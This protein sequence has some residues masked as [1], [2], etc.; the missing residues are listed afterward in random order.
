MQRGREAYFRKRY[1]ESLDLF[2]QVLLSNPS[3][4]E[5]RRMLK[6][7]AQAA[8]D[9]EIALVQKERREILDDMKETGKGAQGLD[10][11]ARQGERHEIASAWGSSFF[12]QNGK[13][14]PGT[15]VGVSQEGRSLDQEVGRPGFQN[16]RKAQAKAVESAPESAEKKFSELYFSG[17]DFY[18]RGELLDARAA[19]ER[20]L[21][22][23]P[24]DAKARKALFRVRNELENAPL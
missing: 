1:A 20:A 15:A 5:A 10:K 23:K 16:P 12:D 21:T 19:W 9:Q 4:P 3:H 2:M 18:S 11:I 6:E 13:A 14:R 17:L 8:A 22:I 7:S 24:E